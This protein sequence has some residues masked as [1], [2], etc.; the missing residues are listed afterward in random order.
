M[1]FIIL[2]PCPMPVPWTSRISRPNS[3]C[4]SLIFFYRPGGKF[5]DLIHIGS[6]HCSWTKI[7]TKLDGLLRRSEKG[8]YGKTVGILQLQNVLPSMLPMN[9]FFGSPDSYQ[10]GHQ[11]NVFIV[12]SYDECKIKRFPSNLFYFFSLFSYFDCWG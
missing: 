1:L 8:T 10:S 9:S 7:P 6:I 3:K 12:S 5:E 4:H 2:V 11:L